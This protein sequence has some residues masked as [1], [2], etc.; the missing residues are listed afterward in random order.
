M[1]MLPWKVDLL[2]GLGS[3][4]GGYY[5]GDPWSLETDREL[6]FVV[7]SMLMIRTVLKSAV[8]AVWGSKWGK[9]IF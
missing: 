3:R 9:N 2:R 6:Q 7:P 1:F 8:C 4:G 5:V